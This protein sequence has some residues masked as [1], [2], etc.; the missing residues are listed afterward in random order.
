MPKVNLN[1]KTTN[2]SADFKRRKANLGRGK[3]RH[4]S[5]TRIDLQTAP[6]KVPVQHRIESASTDPIPFVQQLQDL[7]LWCHSDNPRCVQAGL[8]ALHTLLPK[9]PDLFPNNASAIL[10][11]VLH[12]MRPLEQKIRLEA[13]KLVTWFFS[14]HSKV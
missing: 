2:P 7:L 9:T 13:Q 5:H 14:R 6:L 10:A 8:A 1:K 11:A 3:Q 4:L 12:H